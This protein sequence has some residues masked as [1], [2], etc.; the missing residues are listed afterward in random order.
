MNLIDSFILGFSHN[1]NLL[2]YDGVYKFSL[3]CFQN[4]Y[5]FFLCLSIYLY[6]LSGSLCKV[7]S[8]IPFAPNYTVFILLSF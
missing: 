8:D 7:K 2:K 3:V 4:Y 5:S 1:K 6:F